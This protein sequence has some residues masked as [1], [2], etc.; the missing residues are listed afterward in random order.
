MLDQI[1]G[2][3]DFNPELLFGYQEL[4]EKLKELVVDNNLDVFC[5]QEIELENC[6]LSIY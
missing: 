5:M 2:I 4:R 6:Y 1:N 3:E